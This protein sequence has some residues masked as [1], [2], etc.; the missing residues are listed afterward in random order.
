LK[1]GFCERLRETLIQDQKQTRNL[2]S[3]NHLS[4]FF[5]FQILISQFFLRILFQHY[6]PGADMHRSVRS[7]AARSLRVIAF[8]SLPDLNS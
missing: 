1:K 8:V 3:K 7:Q 2:D 6:R 5:R 4:G